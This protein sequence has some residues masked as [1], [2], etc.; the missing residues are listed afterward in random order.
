VRKPRKYRSRMLLEPIGPAESGESLFE[1]HMLLYDE[2]RCSV[3]IPNQFGKI[4]T[5]VVIRDD[6]TAASCGDS[7]E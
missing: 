5:E 2:S 1:S 3:G 7:V 4:R 6:S